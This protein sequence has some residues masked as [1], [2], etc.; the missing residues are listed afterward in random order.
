MQSG[1]SAPS[2][3]FANMLWYDTTNNIVKMRNEDNDA[4]ISLFTLD[5]S[6]DLVSEISAGKFIGTDTTDA[7]ST[8]AAAV[9]TAGG[10]AVAKKLYVGTGGAVVDGLTVG[11]GAG[12]VSTNTAVGAS[13]LAGANTGGNNTAVGSQALLLNTSGNGA[14]A[15]GRNSMQNNDTGADST[16]VGRN[17]LFSNTTGSNNVGIGKDAL[18]LNATGSN[19]IAV[20]YQSLYTNTTGNLTAVGYQA[21]YSNTTGTALT[22]VGYLSLYSQTTGTWNVALGR[23][24]LYSTTTGGN[25]TSVGSQA[26]FSNTTASYNT[27]VGYQ[28]G[29]SN[30]TGSYNTA[31][32]F[33]A[34]YSTTTAQLLTAIGTTAAYSNTTGEGLV[35]IGHEA[36]YYNTTGAS[37]VAI[38]GYSIYGSVPAALYSNTVGSLNVAVGTGAL[39]SSTNA[40][41]NAA[42]GYRAGYVVSTGQNNVFIG[43][44]AGYD[45]V[46]LTTGSNNIVIGTYSRTSSVSASSQVVIGYNVQGQGDQYVTIGNGNGK[47][48]NSF[49]AN[50]TWTQTSD[51]RLK[52]NIQEDTLGLSFINRLRPV[53]Y[54]WKASNEIDQSLPYYAEENT[55]DTE[56]VMHGLL[57]QEVKAALVAEGVDTFAGW[58]EGPDTI[59]AISREMFVTPLINAVKELK[60]ELDAVKAELAT[61]KGN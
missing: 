18:Y 28:A 19:N 2:T 14:T 1:T 35:A 22:A 45:T 59:Q 54:N 23:E 12:S 29:Y 11:K 8:T 50:A 46:G 53:K 6:G 3:T 55:R 25:N 30:T 57:A 40:D 27:A 36:L 20:G 58:D 4:W 38:G 7:S 13:A 41:G 60:A 39:R 43:R 47:I 61:L 48:Y 37:N 42:L 10:L 51:E 49:T 31:V 33:R 16:A 24:T 5:Q 21:A 15:I 26:L 9:K 32:G 17:S 56:T 52:K 34:L 44:D